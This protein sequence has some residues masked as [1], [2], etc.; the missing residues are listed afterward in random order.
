MSIEGREIKVGKTVYTLEELSIDRTLRLTDIIFRVLDKLSDDVQKEFV[1][2][3]N[4]YRENNDLIITPEEVAEE[5]AAADEFREG[6]DEEA[7]QA[8]GD[9][10]PLRTLLIESGLGPD[11]NEPVSVPKNPS[12]EEIIGFF[13]PKVYSIARPELLTLF[14]LVLAENAK[15]A[16]AEDQEGG[17]DAYLA[18]IANK[19]KHEGKT[20]DLIALL[21]VAWEVGKEEFDRIRSAGNL[22]APL[23][24]LLGDSQASQS[25]EPTPSI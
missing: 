20:A 22:P 21:M 16:E 13:L 24:G 1:E 12:E 4:N 5:K 19:V 2:Y 7:I 25:D 23:S 15:M 10:E 17:V 6:L 9:I 11:I 14:A 3:V 8:A 18:S